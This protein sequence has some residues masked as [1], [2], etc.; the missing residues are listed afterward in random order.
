MVVLS[1]TRSGRNAWRSSSRLLRC[2]SFG[3]V[4]ANHDFGALIASDSREYC[5]FYREE[6]TTRTVWSS[7][8]DWH[9]S[10]RR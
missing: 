5:Q 4:V 8:L 9:R 7:T 6:K 10:S 3:G 1:S 2:R